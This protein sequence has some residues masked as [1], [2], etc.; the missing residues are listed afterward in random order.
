MRDIVWSDP[1]EG[2]DQKRGKENFVHNHVRDCSYFYTYKAVR[3]FLKRNRLETIIRSH[4][5]QNAGCVESF[6]VSPKFLLVRIVYRYRT[7]G[8]RWGKPS[9]ITV[10]SAPN[11]DASK[12]KGAVIKCDGKAWNALNFHGS[13]QRPCRLPQLM[14]A[15]SWSIPFI[16]EKG[17]PTRLPH[18][19]MFVVD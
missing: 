19:I 12:N 17:E 1:I 15:F 18:A 13:S 11:Y 16:C 14:D 2:F 9:L 6:Y 8:M 4:E 3:N 10:F 7:Y 5:W